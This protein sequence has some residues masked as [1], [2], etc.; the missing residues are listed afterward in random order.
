MND[1]DYIS[2]KKLEEIFKKYL[3][4]GGK[5]IH[6]DVRSSYFFSRTFFNG[7]RND[8]SLGEKRR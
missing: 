8:R 3:V 7:I 4:I 1:K 6:R 5:Y 2:K